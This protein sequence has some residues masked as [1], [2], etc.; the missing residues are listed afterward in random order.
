MFDNHNM[1]TISKFGEKKCLKKSINVDIKSSLMFHG[2]TKYTTHIIFHMV[3]SNNIRLILI[4]G[5]PLM[6]PWS[7]NNISQF[8]IM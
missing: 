2:R 1:V 3:D 6:S 4:N 8:H 5:D 7:S